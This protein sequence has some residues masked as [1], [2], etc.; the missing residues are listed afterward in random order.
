M[1]WRKSLKIAV[2]GTDVGGNGIHR[3]DFQAYCC[4][5]A[6]PSSS[7]SFPSSAS[8]IPYLRHSPRGGKGAMPQDVEIRVVPSF[9]PEVGQADV[10]E[11]WEREGG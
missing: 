8:P 7:H 6:F 9:S 1:K 11:Q 5:H 2:L 3:C 4:P 10:H